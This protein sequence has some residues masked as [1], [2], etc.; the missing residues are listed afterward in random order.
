MGAG[1]EK[2]WCELRVIPPEGWEEAVSG[3]LFE[4]GAEAVEERRSGGVKTLVSHLP[5]DES[6]NGR[7]AALGTY[8]AQ[9]KSLS[10]SER[11]PEMTLSRIKERPWVLEARRKF[12]PVELVKGVR[13]A[14]SWSRATGKP[15]ETLL[16]IDPGEA[17]GTGLHPSTRLCARL[18]AE[19]IEKFDGPAVLDVGTGTGI[20]AMA[21]LAK[22][23]REVT[24]TD[25]D[26]RAMETAAENFKNNNMAVNLTSTPVER[27]KKKYHVVVANIFLEELERLAPYLNKVTLPG[28][29]IVLSGLLNAQAPDMIA[30]MNEL[31]FDGADSE[32]RSG[33][34][35]ALRFKK[36]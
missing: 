1:A 36:K 29:Y 16:R 28:G 14:P 13:V 35:R 34:W 17:F 6:L 26:P 5:Q 4:V 24:A 31:G 18:M 21:A 3:Y 33:Q 9:V 7:L 19:A 2:I 32:S 22:G 8:L 27:M 11:L 20:L 30:C 15:G 12:R 10:G 23:A 25:T